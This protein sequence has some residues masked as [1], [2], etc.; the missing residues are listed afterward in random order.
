MAIKELLHVEIER[1]D[2]EDLEEVYDLIRAFTQANKSA[3][4]FQ[5]WPTATARPMSEDAEPLSE[6]QTGEKKTSLFQKLMEIQIDAPE[7]FSVNLDLY[8]FRE[9]HDQD[10]AK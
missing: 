10:D 8:M 3:S 7:D 9:E 5:N 6:Q 2:D 1:L 4:S